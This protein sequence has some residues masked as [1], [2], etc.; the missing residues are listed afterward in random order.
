MACFLAHVVCFSTLAPVLQ[1]L[2][3]LG[4]KVR[5]PLGCPETV[6]EAGQGA[7]FIFPIGSCIMT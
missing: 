4:G 2:R 5:L 1:P 7:I 3:G 6:T